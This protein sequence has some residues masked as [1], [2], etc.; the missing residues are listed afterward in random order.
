MSASIKKSTDSLRMSLGASKIQ[1]VELLGVSSMSHQQTRT[2]K[3]ATSAPFDVLRWVQRLIKANKK[4]EG[5]TRSPPFT[6]H[7]LG[8]T[9]SWF[10]LPS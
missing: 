8:K 5:G 3:G 6:L 7:G 4:G 2:K 10:H 1:L 9:T